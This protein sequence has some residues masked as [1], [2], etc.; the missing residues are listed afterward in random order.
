MI[1]A[2]HEYI[3]ITIKIKKSITVEKLKKRSEIRIVD[4]SPFQF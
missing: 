1:Y 4:L 3:K 2:S